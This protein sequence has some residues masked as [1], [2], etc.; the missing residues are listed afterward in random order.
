M[1]QDPITPATTYWFKLW[2]TQF[3]QGLRFWAAFGGMIPHQSAAELAAE[4]D[5]LKDQ[6]HTDRAA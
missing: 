5:L 4:A 3:E 2:Q 1:Q 6:A